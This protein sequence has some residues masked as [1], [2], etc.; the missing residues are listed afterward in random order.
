VNTVIF[1]QDA[2]QAPV[3]LPRLVPQWHIPAR[4]IG[5][6]TVLKI[7]CQFDW[8]TA[9]EPVASVKTLA[10]AEPMAVSMGTAAGK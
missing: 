10:R 5:R 8:T 9:I 4:R 7:V 1:G 3:P 6:V 2:P